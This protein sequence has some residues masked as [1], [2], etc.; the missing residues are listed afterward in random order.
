MQ[1]KNPL[2]KYEEEKLFFCFFS[3]SHHIFNYAL[4]EGLV[5]VGHNVTYFTPDLP[6]SS[7]ENL[8]VIGFEEAY[9]VYHGYEKFYKKFG[10]STLLYFDC[11]TQF[12]IA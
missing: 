11:H 12:K 10:V 2:I 8:T 3:P 1:G 6:K 4:A 9:E 5:K 7:P